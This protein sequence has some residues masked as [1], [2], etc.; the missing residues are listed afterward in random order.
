MAVAA[1][2]DRDGFPETGGLP[3]LTERRPLLHFA[4]ERVKNRTP[5]EF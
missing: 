2:Y 5:T 3:A 4:E 1:V